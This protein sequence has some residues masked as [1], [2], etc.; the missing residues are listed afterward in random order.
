MLF[1]IADKFKAVM[2][3]SQ[4]N[5]FIIVDMSVNRDVDRSRTVRLSDLDTKI[6]AMLSLPSYVPDPLHPVISKYSKLDSPSVKMFS[7]SVHPD[8]LP[9]MEHHGMLNRFVPM[10]MMLLINV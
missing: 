5:A 4:G 3:H 10:V 1:P 6:A 8:Q 7:K 9:L 2:P